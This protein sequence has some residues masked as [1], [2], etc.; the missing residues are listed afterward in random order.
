MNNEELVK[1]EILA[2]A[3]NLIQQYGLQKVTMQDIAKAAG[4]GKSTLYY[5]FKS[6]EEIFDEVVVQEMNNFFINSKYSVE[7]ESEFK[8]K[9][10][11]YVITKIR[12]LELQRQ[13]YKFLI[14]NDSYY[15]DFNSYFKKMRF[16]YDKKELKL[17]RSI[18]QTGVEAKLINKE[19]LKGEKA[20]LVAELFL[21]SIRG[22]ELEIFVNETFNNLEKKTNLI[23][24]LLIEGLK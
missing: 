23:I 6:K 22:L 3:R 11:A 17:I 4:K 8:D 14:E 16:L 13:K 7:Q 18:L 21:T 5:Y 15:F 19:K 12:T 10:K 2:V 1:D 20:Q 9:L 24:E